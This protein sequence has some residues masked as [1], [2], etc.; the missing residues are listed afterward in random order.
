MTAIV[1]ILNKRAA[2]MA[3]DSAVTVNTDSGTKIYNTATKIFRLSK[4]HPVGVMIFDSASFMG[5]PWDVIFKLYRDRKGDQS[6]NTLEEYARNFLHFLE[7]EDYFSSSKSQQKYLM[8]EVSVYY[9]KV[10]DYAVNAFEE[11]LEE[12]ELTDD[13]ADDLLRTLLKE[14]IDM[15]TEATDDHGVSPEFEH[16]TLAHLRSFGKEALDALAEV[17]EEDGFPADLRD[18]WEEGFY[19]YIRSRLYFS[20]T[21]IVFAGYGSKD[22]YPSILTV[23]ISGAFD[24][25]MRY[26]FSLE[27][28]SDKIDNDNSATIIPYAQVD[29]MLTLMKGIHPGLRR[30]VE[31]KHGESLQ[32]AKEKMLE[33]MKEAGCTKKAIR[34]VEETDLSDIQGNY[35][36][37][38]DQ[39]IQDEFID[40]I[41]DAVNSF[42]IEDMVNMA[43]SLVSV[44][45]LQRHISS[46]EESVGGPIDVAV[47]TRSEGFMW[48]KHK[49]WMPQDADTFPLE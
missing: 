3:A 25:R 44:T 41:V 21:G 33:A 14:R 35:E 4:V 11:Q 28:D 31:S 20:G 27:D 29:V 43:E 17:C 36:E 47:I 30:Y 16:Y 34:Q 5:T 2:V 8:K 13:A 38:M 15:I 10:K 26:Y 32:K 40:G 9:H 45:N 12:N 23:Y 18:A 19:A 1:G 46:S 6:F 49:H 39:F 24:R 7:A 48:V 42:N 37:S 22:I